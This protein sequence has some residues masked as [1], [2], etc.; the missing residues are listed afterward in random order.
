M[1]SRW[2]LTSVNQMSIHWFGI[3]FNRGGVSL[4]SIKCPLCTTGGFLST[5]GGFRLLSIRCPLCS[6][7]GY[8][9]TIG[10]VRLLSI[11]CPCVLLVDFCLP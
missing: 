4:M 10:G 9:S 3:L 5:I 7:G 2:S 11:R 1:Y 8:L 6:T